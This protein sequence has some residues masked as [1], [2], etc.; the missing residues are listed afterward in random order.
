[1]ASAHLWNW[2]KALAALSSS[3]TATPTGATV[4]PRGVVVVSVNR[5]R[6]G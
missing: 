5:Q 4:L 6:L 2:A 3:T 1:M